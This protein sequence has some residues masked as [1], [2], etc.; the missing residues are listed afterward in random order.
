[1]RDIPYGDCFTVDKLWDVRSNPAVPNE[2]IVDVY[3]T[4]PF[5]RSCFFK[6]VRS[7]I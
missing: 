5:S 7:D 3:L 4:V 6:K 1:M 2:I